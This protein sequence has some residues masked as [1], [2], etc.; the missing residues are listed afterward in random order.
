[1]SL[2]STCIKCRKEVNKED[3]FD[4]HEFGLWHCR[5]CDGDFLK[6]LYGFLAIYCKK[7][8]IDKYQRCHKQDQVFSEDK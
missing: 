5:Q 3:V 6:E 8:N 2:F 7:N 1:M 4:D